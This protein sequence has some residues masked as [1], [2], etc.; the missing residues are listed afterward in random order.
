MTILYS[1]RLYKAIRLYKK[2]KGKEQERGKWRNA[3][4]ANAVYEEAEY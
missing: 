2:I 1:I 3:L 4:S